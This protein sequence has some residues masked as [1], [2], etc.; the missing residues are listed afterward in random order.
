VALIGSDTLAPSDSQFVNATVSGSTATCPLTLHYKW[1]LSSVAT[2][3][4][5]AYSVS[6]PAQVSSGIYEIIT[7]PANGVKTTVTVAI[8]Q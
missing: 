8:Q 1:R 3:M 5:I 4:T 7:V 2:N 6:G